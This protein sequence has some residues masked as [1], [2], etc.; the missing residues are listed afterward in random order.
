MADQENRPYKD[1]TLA[2]LGELI[3]GAANHYGRSVGMNEAARRIEDKLGEEAG[4]LFMNGQD[5]E[6]QRLRD[7]IIPRVCDILLEGQREI[8]KYYDEELR[9]PRALVFEELE[10]RDGLGRRVDRS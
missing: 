2:N 5:E 9:Y 3:S 6:A 1:R 10:I 4:R 8:R 7:E